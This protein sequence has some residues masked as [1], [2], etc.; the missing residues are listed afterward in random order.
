MLS[1]ARREDCPRTPRPET[2]HGAEQGRFA[3]A[4][5]ADD[6]HAFARHDAD[7]CFLDDDVPVRQEDA[8]AFESEMPVRVQRV[9]DFLG[10][11][12]DRGQVV[13]RFAEARDPMDRRTP[14]GKA[15][16]V[17]D[18]PSHRPLHL[19]EGAGHHD[20]AA[21][22]QGAAEIGRRGHENR[23]DERQPSGARR[24]PGELRERGGYSPHGVH[25]GRERGFEMPVFVLLS[26]M[27][28]DALA[29]FVDPN[30]GE[31]EF[32]LAR[33]SFAIQCNQRPPDQPGQ[34]GADQGIGEGTPDH[35]TRNG[36]VI[37]SH[38]EHD[39]RRQDPQHPDEG[40]NLEQGIDNA[41]AE[42]GGV[43]AEQT[44]VL[45]N[46]LVRVA[47]IPAGKAQLID[48]HRLEPLDQ[49]VTGDPLAQSKLQ[50]FLEKGLRDRER[51][52]NGNDDEERPKKMD[53]G[54]QVLAADGIE[55]LAV[56][57]VKPHLCRA[58]WRW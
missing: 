14:V 45:L 6:Q 26:A 44:G 43:V 7:V 4:G 56:P 30:E 51:Q 50:A 5:L 18:E 16:E 29:G 49:E 25:D 47:A 53:E 19:G 28:R 35:V 57:L 22:G 12:L 38:L 32:R 1:G 3:R 34:T 33:I 11:F 41:A 27:Q 54:R 40:D 42:V 2:R 9:F 23:N 10:A 46:A 37:A 17:V 21:E 8:H 39:L 55:E 52:Q 36:D 58:C 31:A 48:A 13:E 24:D 15:R 20:Q